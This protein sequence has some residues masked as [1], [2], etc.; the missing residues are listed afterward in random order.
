[1][2]NC[3][4]CQIRKPIDD[5]YKNSH[6]GGVRSACK[7]CYKAKDRA[8]YKAD[9]DKKNAAVATYRAQDPERWKAYQASHF[10][11]NKERLAPIRKKYRDSN[12]EKVKKGQD[13]WRKANPDR[14]RARIRNYQ[15]KKRQATPVWADHEKINTFYA[16]AVAMEKETGYPWEVDHIVPIKSE[17]VCG[18]HNQFNLN[19]LPAFVNKSKSNRKWPDMP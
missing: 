19:I 2:Q 13:D 4:Q 1:M 15:V 3:T 11:A 10:Q 7:E 12:K 6:T 14:Q 16:A 8:N 9:P 5:F 18:L 17:L